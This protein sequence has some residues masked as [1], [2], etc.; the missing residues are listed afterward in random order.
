MLLHEYALQ[1]SLIDNKGGPSLTA[2]GGQITALGYVFAA[3]Q[4]LTLVSPALSATTFSLELSF[5]FDSTSGY[6]KIADFH[7]RVDDSG[8]YQYDGRL[9]LYPHVTAPEVDFVA[10]SVVHVI[11]TRDGATN[12]VTGFVNGQQRISFVD[13]TPTATLTAPDKKLILFADDFYTS[14]GEAS[15]GRVNYIRVFNGALTATE[16]SALF[17]GSAPVVIPEPSTVAMTVVGLA[18]MLGVLRVRSPRGR[19]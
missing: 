7:D 16:V 17:A 18:V 19:R 6:R 9:N 13:S 5:K 2:L 3:N 8:L 14:E 4:G 15:A 10:G 12:V 1:G 11:L